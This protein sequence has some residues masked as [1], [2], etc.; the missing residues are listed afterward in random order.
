VQPL[1][2]DFQNTF[3]RNELLGHFPTWMLT[4]DLTLGYSYTSRY[5]VAYNQN[6]TTLAQ[7]QNIFD[8]IVLNPPVFTKPFTRN[9]FQDSKDFDYYFYDTITVTQP[10][11]LLAGVRWVKDEEVTGAPINAISTSWV[12]SPGYGILYDIRPTTTLFA[13]W[14]EGLE[15]GGTAPANSA[16]ANVV[17]PPAI[18]KQKEIGV[19]DSYFKGFGISV[20]YFEITRANAVTDPVTNIF[21]YN[22]DLEYKGVESTLSYTFLRD[23]TLTGALL[24][25]NAT[26]NSPLQP[27]INGKTPENTPEWNGN[28]SLTYRAPWLPGLQLKFG[29]RS[30]SNRPINAQDQG[31]LPGYTLFDG[32]VSYATLIG[33]R[34]T[35]FQASVDNLSNKR[36]WNSVTTG[37]YGIGMVT[38]VRLSAKVDF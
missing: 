8:P 5:S 3:Y 16:N 21:G 22:G 23:W 25:L 27:L 24:W 32:G 29:I 37:T 18:S 30:I 14:L 4:H 26:Q 33:G 10:L 13:S 34:R 17:L 9:P 12:A 35:S 6:N 15:A 28:V 36:Y 2:N 19:R 7:K 38:A 31:F 11:K 20:S 1:T